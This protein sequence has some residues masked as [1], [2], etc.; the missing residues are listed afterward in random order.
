MLICPSCGK[1]NPDGFRFCGF[2]TA[3][4]A[5]EAA[6]H[7]VRKTVT[8]L[9]SDVTGST[10]LGERLDPESL[11]RVMTRYFDEMRAALERHGG[12]VEKFI[13]DAIMAV[14][15]IP[16]LHEDDAHRAVRAA[17]E[18]RESL[19]A[20]NKELERDWGVT[21][22]ARTGINT[23]EVVAGDPAAGQTLVTG[24]TVNVAARLEQ[25]AAPGEILLGDVTY[26]LTKDG[27]DAEPVEPLT[28]KGKAE[29]V[30][31]F[32]L[33]RVTHGLEV[34]ARRLDSP[35]VGRQGEL[36]LLREAFERSVRDRACLLFTVL[37]PAGVGKSRLIEEFLAGIGDEAQ[38]LRGRCLPYGEG[39]TYWPVVEMLTQA[40]GLS[41][42]DPPDEVRRKVTVLLDEEGHAGQV[43]E[44]LGQV[45][46]LAGATASP[47]ETFWAV[48]KLLEGIARHRPGVVVLDDIHW[49]EPT[50]LDLVDHV[51]DWTRDAPILLLCSAR[52]EL[53]DER[54]GWGGG[55]LNATSFLLEPLSETECEE[56]VENLLEHT[57]LPEGARRHIT[58]AAEG[59]PLFVEQMVAMLIDDGLLQRVE[60]RWVLT[61]DL[62][63]VPVPASIQALIEA[64]L[65][66]L[67]AGE[68]A[69]I[70]RAS[71]EGRVF[72]RNGVLALSGEDLRPDVD[73]H[74]MGLVRRE[75]IR[76]D[77]SLFPGDDAFRFRHLLIRD[78]AYQS[79]P[80]AI[81]AELHER[82]ADWLAGAA[83][84]R[85]A[86]FEEIVGYHLEQA[87]RLRA[88]LGPVDDHGRLVAERGAERLKTAGR[89]ADERGDV[90]AAV[91]LLSRAAALLPSDAP[92][93]REL[94]PDLTR[95][96]GDQGDFARA[97]ELVHEALGIARS[98][99][100]R[101]LE[102][103]IIVAR[104]ML[105]SHTT[106]K[107]FLQEDSLADVQ[108]IVPTLE[109]L[110]DEASLADAWG[111]IGLS[112]FWLGRSPAGQEA[113]RRGLAHA[114]AA[115]DRRRELELLGWLAL[116]YT[117]GPFPL[118]ECVRRCESVLE[119]AGE[120]RRV[121][122]SVLN[123]LG[124]F[125]AGQG[126][127]AEARELCAK[128]RSINEDLGHAV[129]VAGTSMFRGGVELL[130]GDPV[131]A[132]RELRWGYEELDRM[133]EQGFFS[134]V[135]G[136]LACALVE[137]RRYEE[138]EGVAKASEEAGSEDDFITQILWRTA[139]A[140]VRSH[141]ARFEEAERLGS[142]AVEIARRT[143]WIDSQGDALCTLAEV[144]SAAGRADEA[145]PHAREALR[146]YEQKE[147]VVSAGLA[148]DLLSRLE[149]D[150][151]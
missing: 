139:L 10:S 122:S 54:P 105:E 39:I 56:I 103:R 31:A 59:N 74:L 20:L 45:M 138:A 146:L 67:V 73:T 91:N 35:L 21:V 49:G 57:E 95:I 30:A 142:E 53:L 109:E 70:E 125:R 97:E 147:A 151:A 33:L 89:R 134:T 78:A 14:F 44:R 115:S 13:G 40:A 112:H 8:V 131:A 111:F 94:L 117:A 66:R 108:A 26:R 37:G 100:D 135:A 82:F 102:C 144:L 149:A 32:R 114:R 130:A 143:D 133:G 75:L 92:A 55:K 72:H 86:E 124:S 17:A 68:R 101:R 141:Q 38:V 71:V 87:Y 118:G 93:R 83:G 63:S 76:P 106:A 47:D 60:D 79:M 15:G 107:G 96:L 6:P 121:E 12:T 18:M 129:S 9:F 41:A 64:R 52:P 19:A 62:V 85:L 28:L 90:P 98:T 132:E 16:S 65:D 104:A 81:R 69:V 3:S 11:R 88:D 34:V 150:K 137:L 145:A 99:G 120:D 29:P 136:Q 119:E 61:G 22:A 128:A 50:F 5:V 48:R 4:L 27:V 36:Q 77:A 84:D 123:A 23:G 126:R 24:D 127:F 80:K 140:Q 25:A 7:E 2:C 113:L 46:G 116:S 148:R 58:A 1:E 43:A 110:E 51:A 42:L